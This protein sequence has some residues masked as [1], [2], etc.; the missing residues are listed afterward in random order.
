MWEMCLTHIFSKERKIPIGIWCGFTFLFGAHQSDVEGFVQ[1]QWIDIAF[2]EDGHFVVI[3][4]FFSWRWNN[5]KKDDIDQL[6]SFMLLFLSIQTFCSEF[7]FTSETDS[8]RISGEELLW[9]C[10]ISAAFLFY[11]QPFSWG[12]SDADNRRLWC[13][14]SGHVWTR[15]APELP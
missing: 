3:R 4:H 11:T 5:L 13:W 1:R 14:N 12:G 7:F 2:D 10:S 9:R 8:W 6:F 15:T